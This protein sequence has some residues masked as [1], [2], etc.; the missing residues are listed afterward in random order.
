MLNQRKASFRLK[1][2]RTELADL[3]E[4]FVNGTCGDWEWD[5]FLSVPH[6]DPEIEKIHDRCEQ[7]DV[8]FPPTK[9]GQFCNEEGEAILLYYARQLREESSS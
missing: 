5:N 2:T 4:G 9:P 8:E 7:L 1:M 6:D 3:L